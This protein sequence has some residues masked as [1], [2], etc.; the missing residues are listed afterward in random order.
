MPNNTS[1]PSDYRNTLTN[2]FFQKKSILPVYNFGVFIDL[3]TSDDF[4]TEFYH[5]KNIN[6][7]F[8]QFTGEEIRAGHHVF[9]LPVLNHDGFE[10]SVQFE[11]DHRGKIFELINRMQ[12]KL[13]DDQGFYRGYS[14]RIIHNFEMVVMHP[15]GDYVYKVKFHD[16]MLFRVADLTLDYSDNSSIKYDC[17]FKSDYIS[18]S[19]NPEE[20]NTVVEPNTLATIFSGSGN[21]TQ[22]A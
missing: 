9:T 16:T 14:S 10:F 15:H 17:T 4:S 3:S 6:I 7:P 12:S 20:P 5:I 13:I 1:I 2:Q 21:S 11:D 19:V 8:Y 22:T 18:I